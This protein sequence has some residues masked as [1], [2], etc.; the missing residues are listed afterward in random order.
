MKKTPLYEVHCKLGGKIIDFAGWQLPVQY[1]G[2]LEEHRQVRSAAGLFDVS[3]MGRIMVEGKDAEYF[4]NKM[5]TNDITTA[6]DNQAVYSPMCYHHGGVVDDLLVYRFNQEKY[7]VVVNASN[8]EKDLAWFRENLEGKV[9]IKDI[10]DETAQ[11]AIQ[12][13]NAE[14]ILQKLTDEDLS[15]IKFYRF[16]DK[17]QLSGINTLVSRTGYTGEDGFE[18]YLSAGG[19]VKL[20]EELLEKGKE[21]GLVPVGL[22]ARDTLRFE[23]ALPLYGHELSEEITPFEAGLGWF[24]KLSKENFIGKKAL[25]EQKENGVPRILTGFE[26]IDRGVPRKDYEV[27]SD[28]RK[29]GY[30]TTG[31][32]APSLE[33][34]IGLALLEAEYSNEGTMLEIIIRNKP[35]RAVV[36]KKPFYKK[37]YQK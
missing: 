24:V 15:K 7:L 12:G 10:S 5:L 33:K 8:T 17:V 37:K 2:I 16:L 4:L 20:W 13:P 14:R 31:G 9:E 6:K 21:E 28:G 3:H 34:N 27:F 1:T 36:V 11:F 25:A 29:V 19:A 30:V 22:G 18:I 35:A 26:M 32:F 23:A